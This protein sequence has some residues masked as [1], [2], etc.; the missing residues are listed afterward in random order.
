MT[1][2][3][4]FSLF[5]LEDDVTYLNAAYMS[6][7]LKTVEEIGMEALKKK[8]RP[9]EITGDD[10]FLPANTLKESFSKLVHNHDP[11]RIAI[12]PSVSYAM[13]IVANNITLHQGDEIL[14]I[15]DQFPSNIYPWMTKALE[16]MAKVVTVEPPKES[17]DRGKKW[18]EKIL[19]QITSKT[20]LVAMPHVHW[21]DG[22]LF[23]LIA[24]RQRTLEVGALLVIDGTQSVGAL[25]FSIEEIQPDALICAGYKWLLG[26]YSLGCAYFGEFFDQGFPIEESW[27]NRQNSDDFANLVNYQEKYRP[28]AAK[29]S[30]GESSNFNLVP[31]LTASINQLLNWGVKSIETHCEAI[32]NS[33][34][35]ELRN[36]GFEIEDAYY[37][38]SHLFGIKIPKQIDSFSLK[39]EFHNNKIYVSFRGEYIRVAPHLYNDFHDFEKLV[40]VVK[41]NR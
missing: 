2:N 26:P 25:D 33:A 14:V 13:A 15:A 11:A 18:N 28:K 21:A 23:D 34:V 37:R 31:M 22:T 6:P 35:Q 20:R 32:A 36:L 5:S 16:S 41:K 30:V 4:Y 7:L 24:I 38:S 17:K 19:E 27:F 12:I 1:K 3:K 29:Y 8:A 9:Y 40:E 39:E 10:F